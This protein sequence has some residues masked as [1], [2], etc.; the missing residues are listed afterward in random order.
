MAPAAD[1]APVVGDEAENAPVAEDADGTPV[2]GEAQ[3]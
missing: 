1:E 2:E 3:Q